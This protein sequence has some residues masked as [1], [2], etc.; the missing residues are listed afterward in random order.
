MKESAKKK[1]RGRYMCFQEAV[2]R[3]PAYRRGRSAKA[4]GGEYE[5]S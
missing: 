5:S 4:G 1:G 2:G 3:A